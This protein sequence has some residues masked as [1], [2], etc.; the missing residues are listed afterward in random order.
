[1]HCHNTVERRGRQ[2]VEGWFCLPPT[3][4]SFWVQGES[5]A[6]LHLP[7]QRHIDPYKPFFF[8]IRFSYIGEVQV[9]VTPFLSKIHRGTVA[10]VCAFCLSRVPLRAVRICGC[11]VF[12]C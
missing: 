11:G 8:F 5:V 1:M 2:E 10:P 6:V 12:Y 3:M 4:L 7:Q 9:R